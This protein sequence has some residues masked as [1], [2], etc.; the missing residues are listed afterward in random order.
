MVF[1]LR[2]TSS[3]TSKKYGIGFGS[4]LQS[5]QPRFRSVVSNTNTASSQLSQSSTRRVES[6]FPAYN[7]YSNSHNPEGR[8]SNK[9]YSTDVHSNRS[10]IYSQSNTHT[11]TLTAT[12]YP[13]STLEDS[14][15]KYTINRRQ[16]V[17]KDIKK[18]LN[19]YAGKVLSIKNLPFAPPIPTIS[20]PEIKRHKKMISSFNEKRNDESISLRQIIQN[21]SSILSE[22]YWEDREQHQLQLTARKRISQCLVQIRAAS[23]RSFEWQE[24]IRTSSNQLPSSKRLRLILGDV[25]SALF[26]PLDLDEIHPLEFFD[27]QTNAIRHWKAKNCQ[28]RNPDDR[29]DEVSLD[30]EMIPEPQSVLTAC[31]PILN[32]GMRKQLVSHLPASVQIMTCHRLFALARDGDS[33]LSMIHRCNAF[34]HTLLVIETVEGYILGGYT[35]FPWGK[36]ACSTGPSYYGSGQSFLFASHPD[37]SPI[38]S[39]S[40]ELQIFAWT[41]END[42]FQLCNVLDEKLAMGGG[43]NFGMVVQDNFSRGTTASCSTFGNPA[44]IPLQTNV[45]G[46]FEVLNLEIYGFTS[47][48]Q[49]L[50]EKKQ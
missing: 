43:G 1:V 39:Q 36:Q 18:L 13:T 7:H 2:N 29:D 35:C 50:M 9:K 11:F 26:A 6:K 48:S 40:K 44:L 49:S 3:E 15:S 42:F 37:G 5:S 47:M 8:D 19:P 38:K 22:K 41:R 32:Q 4:T 33:F 45:G 25:G 46:T 24:S 10:N 31:P 20:A 34:N 21:A 16:S 28:E 27:Y 12:Y 30:F 23:Q 17:G 14:V